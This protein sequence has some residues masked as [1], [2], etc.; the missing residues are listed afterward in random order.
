MRYGIYMIAVLLLSLSIGACRSSKADHS[1]SA[2]GYSNWQTQPLVIDGS[3][4]DWKKPLPYVESSEKLAY[5]ITHDADNLYVL[6]S[7]KDPVEQEKIISGGITVWVNSQAEKNNDD[8]IGIG[9]PTDLRNNREQQLMSQARPDRYRPQ[10]GSLQD[11]KSYELYGFSRENP[12]EHYDLGQDNNEGIK[13]ALNYNATGELIYESMIPLKNVFPRNNQHY[14]Q[15]K[16]IAVG[17]FIEGIPAPRGGR[18]G[19]IGGSGV[20]VGVGGGMGFGGL[21]GSGVGLGLSLGRSFGGGGGG[22]NGASYKPKK[23]WQVVTLNK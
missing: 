7:T 11:V 8:A 18:G 12:I 1:S 21:G 23:I 15:G 5:A 3:D 22:G 4:S 6:L 16:D 19:G 2:A 10:A 14:Y 20:G 9:F 17:I 13:V